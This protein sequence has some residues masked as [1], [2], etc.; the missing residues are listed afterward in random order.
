MKTNFV[1]YLK[2]KKAQE[3]IDKFAKKYQGKKVV[4]YGAGFFASELLRKYDFSSLNVIGIADKKFER[5]E[6]EF[7]GI[8]KLTPY[9]LLEK[10]FD[11]LLITT[12]DDEPI[13]D[14]LKNDLLQGEDVRFRISTLV[15][16]NLWEYIKFVISG[17]N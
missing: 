6:G 10:E 11:L 14:Y 9:D 5:S 2:K 7:Y 16:M 15:R 4:L 13:R 3:K 8:Q 1:E 17:G 12:Y